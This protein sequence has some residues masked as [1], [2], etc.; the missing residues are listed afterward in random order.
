MGGG[1]IYL[2][3]MIGSLSA[4]RTIE[5]DLFNF[6]TAIIPNLRFFEKVTS[7]DGLRASKNVSNRKFQTLK[8]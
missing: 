8:I 5:A 1:A 4:R 3:G 7:R 6:R 2:F